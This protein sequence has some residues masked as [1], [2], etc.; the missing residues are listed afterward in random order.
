MF[1]LWRNNLFI[2]L[3]IFQENL[4]KHVLS[5][6]LHPGKMIYECDTCRKNN[7]TDIFCT[8]FSKELRSHLVESHQQEFPTANHALTYVSQLFNA[9]D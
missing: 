9:Q 2:S 3:Y 7:N 1:I 5:T 6:R 8:N 4:R